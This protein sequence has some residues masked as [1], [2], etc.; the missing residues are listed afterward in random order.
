MQLTDLH[1]V[2]PHHH[3]PP[4]QIIHPLQTDHQVHHVQVTVAVA[5]QE[6]AAEAEEGDNGLS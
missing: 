4:D 3:Q 1:H 2:L 6:A 5:A